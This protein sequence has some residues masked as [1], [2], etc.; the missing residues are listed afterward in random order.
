MPPTWV[1]FSWELVR[2]ERDNVKQISFFVEA[3]ENAESAASERAPAKEK[4]DL[5]DGEEEKTNLL[6]Q[7]AQR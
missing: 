3:L 7:I 1:D 2:D 4:R 6:L 5:E